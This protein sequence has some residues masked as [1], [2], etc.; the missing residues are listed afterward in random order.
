MRMALFWW[1]PINF[2][3]KICWR[4]TCLRL[5]S[6][7]RKKQYFHFEI[8]HRKNLLRICF[9]DVADNFSVID[10]RMETI[11]DVFSSTPR[12]WKG[13]FNASGAIL[14]CRVVN[15]P[16]STCGDKLAAHKI[17]IK[18][19]GNSIHSEKRGKLDRSNW[20]EMREKMCYVWRPKSL[21]REK[22]EI[23]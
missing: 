13:K 6:F 19:V 2:L 21:N 7:W 3:A 10:K 5:A 4:S 22:R 17:P 9:M 20:I 12:L 15:F 18:T 11:S 23:Q 8:A 16:Y 14:R 1:L